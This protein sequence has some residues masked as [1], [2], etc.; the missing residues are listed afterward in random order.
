MRRPLT[1]RWLIASAFF[2]LSGVALGA[3]AAHFLKSR[4]EPRAFEIFEVG[5]RYQM[6]HALLLGV[7]GVLEHN[8]RQGSQRAGLTWAGVL[9]TCGTV[10]FSGSLYL[11]A[12]TGQRWLGAITPIGGVALLAGWGA[13]LRASL[14]LSSQVR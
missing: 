7:F 5:A 4:L 9:V 2:G 11:L 6:Y 8:G 12:F 1:Q 13:F 14:S 10:V 3:F